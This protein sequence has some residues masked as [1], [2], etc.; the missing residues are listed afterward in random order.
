LPVLSG[1]GAELITQGR[2]L[3]DRLCA[4]MNAIDPDNTYLVRRSPSA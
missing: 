4:E 2:E 1:N 3:I